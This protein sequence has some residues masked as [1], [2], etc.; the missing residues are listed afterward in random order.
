MSAERKL[1]VEKAEGDHSPLGP[2]SAERWINCPGSVRL[3]RHLPDKPS[4][5]AVEGTAAHKVAEECE[6]LGVDALH[7]LDWTVVVRESGE[8]FGVLVDREMVDAVQEF[9]DYVDE[10]NGDSLNE[11][12]VRFES[13]V[14]GGFGTLD[15]AKVDTR[16]VHLFDFKYGQ[17]KEVAAVDNPQLKLLA[18]GFE[19]D[20]SWL[21]PGVEEYVL[22]I[23]QPRIGNVSHWPI[24]RADLLAWGQATVKPRAR[25]A[26]EADAPTLA[27]GDWCTF[28]KIRSTCMV[29]AS[30]VFSAVTDDFTNLDAALADVET[31]GVQPALTPEQVDRALRVAPQIKAWLSD[32]ETHA[33]AELS[34]GH[35]IGAWKMVEGRAN[36][37]WAKPDPDIVMALRAAGA[38]DDDIYKPRQLV[39]PAVAEKLPCIGKAHPLMKTLV[40]KPKGKPVLAPG[41]DPRPALV[42]DARNEFADLD[43]GGMS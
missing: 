5:Y 41:D 4:A 27:A 6:R 37:E 9:L 3:T 18:L 26:L 19:E 31:L 38:K 28:C 23:V 12:K 10:F 11:S 20:Y 40:V 43:A 42:V 1:L 13:L 35:V 15:R 24:K 16:V 7:F 22:H 32:L 34:K 25:E 21:A 2:S 30:A 36:R 33:V 17:G 14:P 29:R 8:T 39:G